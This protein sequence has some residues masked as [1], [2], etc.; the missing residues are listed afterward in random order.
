M[1]RPQLVSALNYLLNENVKN[2]KKL[3][4]N[5]SIYTL[6]SIPNTENNKNYDKVLKKSALSLVDKRILNH[7]AENLHFKDQ[8]EDMMYNLKK[9]VNTEDEALKKVLEDKIIQ[10][11]EFNIN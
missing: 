5:S 10:V 3:K 1:Y 6:L 11:S 2:F 4:E 9:Y 8:N 7:Y